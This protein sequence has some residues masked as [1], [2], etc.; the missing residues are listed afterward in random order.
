M[1]ICGFG[2]NRL[3]PTELAVMFV[4]E[5]VK[6]TGSNTLRCRQTKPSPAMSS[7]QLGCAGLDLFLLQDGAAFASAFLCI[8]LRYSAS[9]G[10]EQSL[11]LSCKSNSF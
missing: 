5:A 3:Q 4:L 9:A 10:N 7:V 2:Q 1:C 6:V 8:V 11:L